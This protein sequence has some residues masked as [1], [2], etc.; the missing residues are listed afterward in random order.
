MMQKHCSYVWI[1]CVV[2]LGGVGGEGGVCIVLQRN[3]F[4][5]YLLQYDAKTLFLC[6]DKYC[7]FRLVGG[8]KCSHCIAQTFCLLPIYSAWLA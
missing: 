3:W 6:L 5:P 4:A 1:N 7:G 8:N 2:S